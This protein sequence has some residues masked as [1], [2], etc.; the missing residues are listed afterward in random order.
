MSLVHKAGPRN[1]QHAGR[2]K[3]SNHIGITLNPKIGEVQYCKWYVVM[4]IPRDFFL[5]EHSILR[6]F[7]LSSLKFTVELGIEAT[8]KLGF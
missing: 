8:E 6:I 4:C 3:F 7:K 1:T 2:W 5:S